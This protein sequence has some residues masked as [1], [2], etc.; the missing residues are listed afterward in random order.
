MTISGDLKCSPSGSESPHRESA[1]S[2]EEFLL[3]HHSGLPEGGSRFPEEASKEADGGRSKDT[4]G[5]Y[6]RVPR[7]ADYALIEA[8]HDT[9]D[10][11][12]EDYTNAKLAYAMQVDRIAQALLSPSHNREKADG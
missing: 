5:E 9:R 1:S 2:V 3:E 6:V 7:E 10:W 11:E 8:M 12:A 4:R